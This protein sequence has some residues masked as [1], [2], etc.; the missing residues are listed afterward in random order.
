MNPWESNYK[1]HQGNV[2][3]GRAIAY[4]TAN[5][6]PVLLPLNDTQKYDLVVDK[7]DQLQRVSVKTTQGMNKTG[8]YYVVQLKNCGGASGKS[9]IRHFDN[10]SCDILFIVTIE[11]TLYEIPAKDVEVS[12]QLTL[13]EDWNK[14]IVRLDW[15]TSASKE[16]QNVEE[17]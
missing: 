12:G 9:T 2:G 15:G 7:D 3:L 11:G 5:C 16:I 1:S 4:Y 8:K 6:I 17:G 13:T 14:Y 10:T